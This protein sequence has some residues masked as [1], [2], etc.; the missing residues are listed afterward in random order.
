MVA[1][2]AGIL[3]YCLH[4]GIFYHMDIFVSMEHNTK[5]ALILCDSLTYQTHSTLKSLFLPTKNKLVCER[6][7]K[8]EKSSIYIESLL[9][10][11]V[12]DRVL[13]RSCPYNH[14]SANV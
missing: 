1:S 11:G 6:E 14:L 9:K 12:L 13:H 10:N 8:R 4:T 7:P 2:A 5:K 3:E